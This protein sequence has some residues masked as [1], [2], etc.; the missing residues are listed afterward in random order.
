MNII[1]RVFRIIIT[2]YLVK[3]IRNMIEG[4]SKGRK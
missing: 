1:K 4:N 2:G 3:W